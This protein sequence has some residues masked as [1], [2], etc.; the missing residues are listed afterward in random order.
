MLCRQKFRNDLSITY[1]AQKLNTELSSRAI[2]KTLIL[3]KISHEFYYEN[4]A[5]SRHIK[6]E[7]M[8]FCDVEKTCK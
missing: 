5:K 4:K 3:F 1:D 7:I 8:F 6:I 2:N